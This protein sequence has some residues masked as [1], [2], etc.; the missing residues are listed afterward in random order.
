MG[1]RR[2]FAEVLATIPHAKTFDINGTERTY[3][4]TEEERISAAREEIIREDDA[5]RVVTTK[6]A[7]KRRAR[8]NAAAQELLEALRIAE[9]FMAGFEGDKQQVGIDEMLSMVRA[10][11]AKA[12]A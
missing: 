10:A 7:R 3:T 2:T 4:F 11:I 12:G 9:A 5:E 6:A 8:L 1:D